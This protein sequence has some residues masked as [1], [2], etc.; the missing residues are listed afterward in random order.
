MLV[1][2]PFAAPNHSRRSMPLCRLSGWTAPA[3]RQVSGF[4]FYLS[5]H[6]HHAEA[7]TLTHTPCVVPLFPLVVVSSPCS[8]VCLRFLHVHL[9]VMSPLAQSNSPTCPMWR[10]LC[11]SRPPRPPVARHRA[12]LLLAHPRPP[13]TPAACPP[14]SPCPRTLGTTQLWGAVWPR[15][16]PGWMQSSWAPSQSLG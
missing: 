4:S 12:L 3:T 5:L 9:V 2:S 11:P 1:P 15:R 13:R 16:S 6:A 7:L 10:I 8:V 14:G